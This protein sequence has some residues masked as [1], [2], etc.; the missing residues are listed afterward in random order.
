MSRCKRIGLFT[1]YPE[2]T[3]A[4]RILEGIMGQCRKYDYDLCVFASSVHLSFPHENYIRGES[5]IFLL[6][7]P[8]CLDGVILDSISLTGDPGDRVLKR[9]S[10]RL[11]QYGR[12]P[13]CTLEYPVDGVPLKL[14]E[15]DQKWAGI[16]DTFLF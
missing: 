11:L 7:N 16:R 5:N 6:A 8:D 9:L 10:E 14:S 15:K 4:R 3:H 2:T 13:M 1:A 12:L